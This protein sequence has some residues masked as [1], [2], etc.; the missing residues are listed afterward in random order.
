[1]THAHTI[2]TEHL[3][4]LSQRGLPVTALIAVRFAACVTTW[5][6]RHR[7][8]KTLGQL[9]PWQ[10]RDVGLTR[11]QASSEASRVFWMA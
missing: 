7:T 10:L 5:A 11:D 4:I 2:S 8:R 9:E 6:T 1:M 3:G